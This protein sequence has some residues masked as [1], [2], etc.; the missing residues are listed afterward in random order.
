M[1]D[2]P[3]W[4]TALKW[5]L[6]AAIMSLVMG[7]LGRSRFRTRPLSDARRLAHPPSTL[8]L[9][10]AG[11]AFFAGIA[12]LSNV[13]A[14]RTTTWWTTAIFVG[15][16]LLSVPLVIDYFAA[17]HE[18]SAEGLSYRKLVGTRK[19]LRWRELRDVRFAPVM[20]WFRLETEAGDV[21]RISVM[22]MG[23]PEFA[24]LLLEHAP[25]GAIEPGTL[26]VLRATAE[27]A[28]PSVWS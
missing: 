8:I 14:N 6:W 18:V 23:L 26:D 21:A 9:G 20:K 7:W 19:Y 15:C 10:L 11:S 16:A 28:P 12:V 2:R 4:I 24:R 3:W 22:L 25:A 13:F 27:G 17:R 1:S 5:A